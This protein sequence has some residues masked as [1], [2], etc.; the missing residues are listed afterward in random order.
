MSAFDPSALRPSDLDRMLSESEQSLRR[1]HEATS[2]LEAITGEGQAADG[3]I[4]A[5]VDHGGRL[6]D[7]ALDPRALRQDSR[8]L[9]ESI[10]EAVQAAQDDAF[11][12]GQELLASVLGDDARNPFDLDA[13][14]DQLQAA[15]ETFARSLDGHTDAFR[16]FGRPGGTV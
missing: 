9:A 11:R 6:R 15:E 7:I 4:R 1:L 10:T 14:R 13:L 12:K 3:L 2:E 8:T 16:R 5:T